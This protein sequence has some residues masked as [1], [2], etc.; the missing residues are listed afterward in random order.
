[1]QDAFDVQDFDTLDRLGHTVKGTSY[2]YGFKG[3]GDIAHAIQMAA[4]ARDLDAGRDH[5]AR[6]YLYLDEVQVELAEE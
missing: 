5:I 3:M 6:L 1:M 4:R 2:G